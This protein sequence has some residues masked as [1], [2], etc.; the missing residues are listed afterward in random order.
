MKNPLRLVS[1]K[2][3]K[4]ILSSFFLVTLV[5]IILIVLVISGRERKAVKEDVENRKRT[6]R[7]LMDSLGFGME[8]FYRESRDMQDGIIYPLRQPRRFWSREVV[9]SYWIDPAEAGL[10]TLTEDNDKLILES[11]DVL[12]EKQP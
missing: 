4:Y 7:A 12:E 5:S 8:D 10:Q 2:G 3:L 9:D 1:G 6:D 11:L